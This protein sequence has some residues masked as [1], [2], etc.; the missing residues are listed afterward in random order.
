M[1]HRG[2]VADKNLYDADYKL[3]TVF[4]AGEH[5]NWHEVA[6]LA[7]DLSDNMVMPEGLDPPGFISP[8]RPGRFTGRLVSNTAVELM[9]RSQLQ[10]YRRTV[11]LVDPE[12]AHQDLIG[13]LLPHCLSVK[14]LTARPRR[15]DTFSDRV[16]ETY[17][18]PLTVSDNPSAF[19]DCVLVVDPSGVRPSTAGLYTLTAADQAGEGTLSY[20]RVRLPGDAEPACGDVEAHIF[21]AALYELSGSET[22][23]ALWASEAR[24]SGRL[25]SFEALSLEF[26]RMAAKVS[27]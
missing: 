5:I 13:R 11:G 2:V 10:L 19:S 17:G 3:L 6:R 23:G 1:P 7:G 8:F 22:A 15:Y 16:L 9:R 12:G 21:L 24:L 18:V 26:D 27:V 25:V 14:V 4:P 20:L